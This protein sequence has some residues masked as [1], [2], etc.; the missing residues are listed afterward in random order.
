MR[1]GRLRAHPRA[2]GADRRLRPMLLFVLRRAASA[3]G[4]S[5]A[6]VILVFFLLQVGGVDPAR[7]LLGEDATEAQVA[8]RAA[9]LGT[10][11]PPVEQFEQWV[12]S[13]PD[14]LGR[15]WATN[16]TIVESLRFRGPP[17]LSLAVGSILVTILVG[18]PIGLVAGVRRG[19]TDRLLQILVIAAFALPGFWLAMVLVS[20]VAL[21]VNVI[22]AIGYTRLSSSPT[23]WFLGLILPVTALAISSIASVAQQFRNSVISVYSQEFVRTLRSRGLSEREILFRNVLRN[24]SPPTITIIALQSIAVLGGSVIVERVFSIQGLGSMAIDAVNNADMPAMMGVVVF[25]A[26]VV[27]GVTLLLDI[28]YGFANPKVRLQ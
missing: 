19:L 28:A 13:L 1:G 3:V 10:D 16:L 26:L 15:S 23:Q 21:N 11:R 22:P 5:I 7:A 27:V 4:F 2:S 18:I 12:R 25:S 9:E 24:A 6:V 8:Q 17:T 14:G 20:T